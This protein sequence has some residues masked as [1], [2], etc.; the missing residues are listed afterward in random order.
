MKQKFVILFVLTNF[1]LS[2]VFPFGYETTQA[3]TASGYTLK[4]TAFYTAP[5][6]SEGLLPIYRL[7]K[8]SITEHIYT[9]SEEEKTDAIDN[10]GYTL[11]NT[12]FY[13]NS[14]NILAGT[15]PQEGLL[16][17]YRLYNESTGSRIYTISE[18][19]KKDLMD[20]SSF[21][22]DPTTSTDGIAFYAY[23]NA[24]IKTGLLPVYEFY[25]ETTGDYIYTTSENE[26]TTLLTETSSAAPNANLGPE[27]S[28]GLWN[29]NKK[30]LNDSPF[31]I[32]ANKN[33]NVKDKDGNILAQVAAGTITRVASHTVYHH[34]KRKR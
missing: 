25:N 18:T 1:I 7:Y 2:S 4:S 20:N 29:N 30:T 17:V 23:S 19:A 33:Y 14:T 9:I 34:S 26:K 8:A 13:A 5:S 3:A 15:T 28:V 12:A 27:I 32:K 21:A 16:P 22:L 6:S 24:T 10:L 31:K 11:E